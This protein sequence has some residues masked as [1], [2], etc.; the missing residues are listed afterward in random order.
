M[1]KRIKTILKLFI[2]VV[3]IAHQQVY[4]A[5]YDFKEL[6]PSDKTT[7]VRGK[8]FLYK[9]IHLEKNKIVIKKLRNN[10]DSEHAATISIG[11]FDSKRNNIGIINHCSTD[12]IIESNDEVN[13]FTIEIDESRLEE[14]FSYKKIKYFSVLSENSTCRLGGSKE[15]IGRKVENIS[16]SGSD[17]L[18]EST[19]ILI[20]ML[21]V[22]VIV[23][24]IIFV[25][26]F[27]FT[28][29]YQNMNGDDVR[30]EYQYKQKERNKKKASEKPKKEPSTEKF[31]FNGKSEKIVK[32]ET[33]ENS[34]KR[35][36]QSD[37][38]NFYK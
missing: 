19:K 22:I 1:K 3:I 7:T 13:N 35:K 16:I 4:A 28:S 37:L 8:L 34:K 26:K 27:L 9:D 10:S 25:Y 29:A 15:F 30:K 12:K 18:S 11:L 14:D 24:F 20:S 21:K 23:L 31:M 38:H 5:N 33:E 36:G 6:I 17:E 32:Q 2:L